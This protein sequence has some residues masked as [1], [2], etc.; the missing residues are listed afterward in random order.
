MPKLADP[1]Y[2]YVTQRSRPSQLVPR[3]QLR[4]TVM[5]AHGW[6]GQDLVR[7]PMRR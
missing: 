5:A 1:C 6:P 3:S 7:V 2:G 4:V